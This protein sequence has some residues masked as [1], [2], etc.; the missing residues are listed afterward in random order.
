[1]E[2]GEEE[3]EGGDDVRRSRNRASLR[4]GG[5]EGILIFG[6]EGFEGFAAWF[7]F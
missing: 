2:E 1:M 4:E 7:R 6:E 5:G 3:E